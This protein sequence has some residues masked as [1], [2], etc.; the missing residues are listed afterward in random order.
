MTL[1]VF[2]LLALISS[3]TC[4]GD[5]E[6]EQFKLMKWDNLK[7]LH[8]ESSMAR[9]GTVSEKQSKSNNLA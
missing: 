4:L 5:Q 2:M 7:L 9:A 1:L 3:C 8:S 6:D